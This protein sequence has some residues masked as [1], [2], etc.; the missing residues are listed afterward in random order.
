MES[1]CMC[2]NILFM[3]TMV[4]DFVASECYIFLT[5]LHNCVPPYNVTYLESFI[6]W[7]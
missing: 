1:A 5:I 2:I 4:R 6:P 3:Y 7:Q